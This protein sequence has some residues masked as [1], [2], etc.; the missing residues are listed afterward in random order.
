[1]Y[2]NVS[3]QRRDAFYALQDQEPKLVP[4][5]DVRTRWNSTFLML[6]RAK[7]LQSVFDTFCSQYEQPHFALSSGEWRQIEYLLFILEPFFRFTSLVSRTKDSS[8]HLVFTIYNRIFDHLERAIA[9][10]RRKKVPWKQ[11]MQS[12]LEAA[13]E[14]LSKYYRHRQY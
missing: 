1:M 4:I 3:P 7:R 5:Q 9:A 2:I 8:I 12:A 14:K 11:L 10:L 13:S 6:R